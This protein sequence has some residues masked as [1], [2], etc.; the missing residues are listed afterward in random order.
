M[1]LNP[2]APV[3]SLPPAAPAAVGDIMTKRLVTVGM[4]D[5][6]A[7][8]QM[9]FRAHQFHHLLVLE[10]RTLVGVISDRDLLKALSPRIGTPN[11]TE[12]D[13]TTLNRRAH[14]IMTRRPVT[15]PRDWGVDAAARRMLEANVSSLPVVATDGDDVL[16][17][18][19]TWKD[20]LRALLPPPTA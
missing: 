8:V 7:V 15:V 10:G 5:T 20:L 9:L 11:E 3:T 12:R 6:L 18:I 1:V 17:G 13:R 19:V 16:V 4:D 2:A 14:Q